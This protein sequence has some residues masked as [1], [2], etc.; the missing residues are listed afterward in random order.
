MTTQRLAMQHGHVS[1]AAGACPVVGTEPQSTL[2]YAHPTKPSTIEAN[3]DGQ[4]NLSAK[5]L[6]VALT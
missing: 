5:R 1:R 2:S 3:F 6:R 4:W